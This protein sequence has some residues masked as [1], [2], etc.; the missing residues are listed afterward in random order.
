MARDD[1]T[2]TFTKFKSGRYRLGD[3]RVKKHVHWP[4]EFCSVGDNLKMPTYKDINVYQWVQG[5]SRCVLEESDLQI[6]THMLTYQGHLMQ[7]ALE[8]TWSPVKRAHA[9]VLTEIESGQQSWGDQIQ[10]DQKRQR[11]TQRALKT[12]PASTSDEQTRICKHY[13]EGNCN[14]NKNHVEG[15][16]TYRHACFACYKSIKR[17]YPQPEEKCNRAYSA[18][19]PTK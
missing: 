6:R 5:F 17:H 2:G 13:N 7:D 10:I 15:R 9:A 1:N 3:Q 4:H 8:L 14:H 19:P 16:I 18:S 11:F 12:Q